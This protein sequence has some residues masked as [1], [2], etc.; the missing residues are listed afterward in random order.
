MISY[1]RAERLKPVRKAFVRP[2]RTAVRRGR[3][4]RKMRKIRREAVFSA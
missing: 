1:P 3:T 4:D 2:A